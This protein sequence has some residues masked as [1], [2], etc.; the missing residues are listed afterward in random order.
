M[1]SF[2]YVNEHVCSYLYITTYVYISVCAYIFILGKNNEIDVED[3]REKLI[4]IYIYI[5]IH[6]NKNIHICI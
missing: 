6:M 1:H 2:I 4:Y 5:Y 3:S